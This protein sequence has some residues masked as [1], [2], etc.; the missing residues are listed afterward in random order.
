MRYVLDASIA[1]RW[2][3]PGPLSPK[4]LQ[5]RDDYLSKVHDLL[6]PDIFPAET[7]SALTK[8][9]RQKLI[10]VGQ[11]AQLYAD[12]ATAWPAFL[13]FLPLTGR[14][15]D[16]SSQTRSGFYDCLYVALAEREGCEMVTADERLLKN[17]QGRFPFIVHLS[18]LP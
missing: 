13:S 14:A 10:Q 3:I 2:V 6:A 17:L 11:G 9:E 1:V 18:A 16:I 7:A 15:L 12:V 8:A 5:L 4:A